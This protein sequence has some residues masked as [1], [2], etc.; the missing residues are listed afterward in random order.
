M[1]R[2]NCVACV[3]SIFYEAWFLTCIYNYIN[4]ALFSVAYFVI[5]YYI[6]RFVPFSVILFRKC[7]ILIKL[8]ASLIT[9]N[10]SN[11]EASFWLKGSWWASS[12]YSSFCWPRRHLAASLE[13][14]F[15][16][17]SLK[18]VKQIPNTILFQQRHL[19]D[20]RSVEPIHSVELNF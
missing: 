6:L 2:L 13:R 7:L 1:C 5:I 18:K 10:L 19:V 11:W 17:S 15:R 20:W 9:D 14:F 3:L 16:C 8:F 4:Q 12:E